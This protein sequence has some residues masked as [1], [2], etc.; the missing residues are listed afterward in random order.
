MVPPSIIL[1]LFGIIGN[2][3]WMGIVESDVIRKKGYF[4]PPVIKHVNRPKITPNSDFN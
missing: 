1:I 4:Y 3:R 2:A